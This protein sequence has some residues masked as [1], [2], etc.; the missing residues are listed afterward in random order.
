MPSRKPL[1]GCFAVLMLVAGCGTKPAS[2]EF[3]KLTEDFVYL[4][5]A[6]SPAGATQSGYHTHNGIVLDELLDDYGPAGIAASRHFLTGMQSRI[7]LLDEASLSKEEAAD[8]EIMRNNIGISLLELDSIQNYKHNP[9][10]YVELAGNALF[11]CYMLDYAPI[12]KRFGHIIK[13]MQRLPVLFAQAKTN[14]VDAPE[15]WNRVAQE[16]NQGNI[17]LI[18]KT[19]RQAAPAALKEEYARAAEPAIAALRDFSTFLKDTLSKRTSDWRLGKDKYARKFQYVLTTGKTPEQLLAEAEAELMTTRDAMA[20]L[21][22]PRP[23]GGPW[24]RSLNSMPRRIPILRKPTRRW[25]KPRYSCAIRTCSRCPR[26][27]I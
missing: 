1:V 5:L 19:L 10:V 14:L 6:L 4:N 24:M 12:E 23:C 8:L 2:G 27:A 16:E 13:R 3:N 11:E 15:V 22:A 25:N 21:A 26:A 9:T 7:A 18:D 20:K 17:D